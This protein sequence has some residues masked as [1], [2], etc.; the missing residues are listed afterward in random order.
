MGIC[1]PGLDSK[2]CLDSILCSP[3]ANK[4]TEPLDNLYSTVLKAHFDMENKQICKN[5]RS[6]MTK[7]LGAF[8]PLSITSLNTL[9]QHMPVNAT[10]NGTVV[11]VVGHMGSLLSNVTSS[12]STLPIAPLHTSFRDFLTDETRSREFYVNPEDAHDEFALA[13]LRMMQAELRFNMC[14]LE[15]SYL[16]NSEVVEVVDLK[17]RVED[18]IPFALSYSLHFWADHLAHVSKF[19]SDVFE[20]LQAFMREKFLF[21]LEV[22]SVRGEVA[23]ANSALLS[24][25]GYLN[26]LHDKVSISMMFPSVFAY[27]SRLR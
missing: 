12:N 27:E 17:K 7:V 23:V 26:Q 20:S 9:R 21:W 8:E 15:T 13:T 6:I 5:F 25:Q 16:P 19:S 11:G 1:C 18:N 4:A 22:L 14:K 24:L 2:Y 3:Q 10:V